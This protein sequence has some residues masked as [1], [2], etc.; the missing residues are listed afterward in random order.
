MHLKIDF[1]P[2]NLKILIVSKENYSF[3]DKI[4]NFFKNYQAKIFY[5]SQLP[6]F[7]DIYQY[8]FL[9]NFP[10]KEVEKIL[11]NEKVLSA[12][13]IILIFK[14]QKKAAEKAATEFKKNKKVKII[15]L[16]GE[17]INEKNLENLLWFGLISQ[18]EYYLKLSSLGDY[19]TKK[20]NKDGEKKVKF[21]L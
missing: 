13:R 7:F 11:K 16:E 19:N 18:G 17:E 1:L 10:I 4:K 15:F 6:P 2:E 14:D 8:F 12:K 5:S 21:F 3:I 20:K 9:I